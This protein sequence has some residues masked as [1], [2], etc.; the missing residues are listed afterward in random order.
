[1]GYPGD[2]SES[3]YCAGANIANYARSGYDESS[4]ELCLTYFHRVV[5]S[6]VLQIHFSNGACLLVAS[7]QYRVGLVGYEGAISL[8]L[9]Y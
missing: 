5:R 3:P 8:K 7:Q 4:Q 6:L 1:M 2:S 9:L